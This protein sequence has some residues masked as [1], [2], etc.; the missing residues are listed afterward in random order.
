MELAKAK[1]EL[2]CLR[3]DAEKV[4]NRLNFV[5]SAVHHLQEK[6]DM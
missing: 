3:K 6:Q 2:Q 5:L 1:N 4:N